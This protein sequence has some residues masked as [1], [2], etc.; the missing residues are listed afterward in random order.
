MINERLFVADVSLKDSLKD[1]DYE[2]LCE[3]EEDPRVKFD[4]ETYL[5]VNAENI[6][7]IAKEYSLKFKPLKYALTENI[8]DSGE[9]ETSLSEIA[10]EDEDIRTFIYNHV[11][12]NKKLIK[13]FEKEILDYV[14]TELYKKTDEEIIDDFALCNYGKYIAFYLRKVCYKM[15]IEYLQKRY[16]SIFSEQVTI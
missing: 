11:E 10:E 7:A 2:K 1:E 9:I 13:R 15:H 3:R 4:G 12:G 6:D 14:V 16:K 8:I 5:I